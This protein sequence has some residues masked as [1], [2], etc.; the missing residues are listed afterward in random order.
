MSEQSLNQF[1]DR[2]AAAV[3]A[4]DVDGLLDLYDGDVRLFDLWVVWAYDGAPAWR[5]AVTEWFASLGDQRVRVAFEDVQTA[6]SGDLASLNATIS[7][8][9]V[10][11]D[12]TEQKSMQNR[13]TWVLKKSA[14]QDWKIA[15]EHTSAPVDFETSK[16][17]LQRQ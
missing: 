3:F 10:D 6:A 14:G 11:V 5:Q 16:V 2:Y 1:P 15:H 13:L 9:D 17:I 7:Y 12:G 4:K 8:N